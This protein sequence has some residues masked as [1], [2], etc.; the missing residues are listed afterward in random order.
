[1]TENSVIFKGNRD[2]IIIYLDENIAYEDL[3]YELNKKL[4]DS[5]TFFGDTS[6]TIY[7]HGRRLTSFQEEELTYL[8]KNNTNLKVN[9]FLENHQK[10]DN[11]EIELQKI[12][13]NNKIIRNYKKENE[14]NTKKQEKP[15]FRKSLEEKIID[16]TSHFKNR[17]KKDK[18]IE[19]LNLSN[20]KY[21][22]GSLR[23]G[24]SLSFDG[25]V[26]IVGDVNPGA[27]IISV[28]NVIVLGSLKGVVHAGYTNNQE[29]FVAAICF[30]PTQIRIA[31]LITYIPKEKRV[32]DA[33]KMAYIENSKIYISDL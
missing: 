27:E 20:T 16:A 33:P 9:F 29:A 15:K 26:V 23:N 7:F 11:N 2:G 24:M 21:H 12:N 4:K 5:S 6:A 30:N 17:N 19:K 32:L 13:S 1:M 8:V 3:K 10:Y 31:D 25:S 28:G 14:E 18:N 22:K